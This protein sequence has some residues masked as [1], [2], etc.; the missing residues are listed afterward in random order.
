M[1]RHSGVETKKPDSNGK[2]HHDFCP[3]ERHLQKA[4]AKVKSMTESGMFGMLGSYWME[5]GTWAAQGA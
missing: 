3:R 1:R 2:D 5:K 4:K